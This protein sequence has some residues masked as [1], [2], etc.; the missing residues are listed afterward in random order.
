MPR[1]GESL[2]CLVILFGLSCTQDV[3]DPASF[4]VG[5]SQGASSSSAGSSD[6]G[7]ASLTSTSAADSAQDTGPAESTG[8][9]ANDSTGAATGPGPGDSGG[10]GCGDGVVSPGEQCDGAML[11]GFDCGSLGLGAGTLGCDPVTCT[12]D[13]SMCSGGGGGTGGLE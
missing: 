11:Q 8:N 1:A 2:A 5:N 3:D 12:F 6:D 10:G 9:G 7:N 13:T 4:T